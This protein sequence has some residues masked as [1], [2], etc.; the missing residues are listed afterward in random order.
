[1]RNAILSIIGLF[2]LLLSPVGLSAQPYGEVISGNS[3]AAQRVVL[4]ESWIEEWD[5]ATQS[6]V[7]IEEEPA[8]ALSPAHPR[9]E[10]VFAPTFQPQVAPQASDNSAQYGPFKVLDENRVALVGPTDR[11]SPQYF[12]MMLADHPGLEVFEIIEGPGTSDDVGNLAVGRKIREA[13]MVTYVP[14]GGSVRSGAVELFLAGADRQIAEGAEFAVHSWRDTYGREPK[15]YAPDSAE[16]RFYLDYYEEMGMPTDH[17][18]A[19]YDMT[20]SVPHV[21]ALWLNAA[22]MREWTGPMETVV[23]AESAVETDELQID[24]VPVVIPPVTQM[25]LPPIQMTH[26][27]AYEIANTDVSLLDSGLAFP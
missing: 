19:F 9:A 8:Q 7:R 25:E 17:A 23:T 22:D 16:N 20:N 26:T 27:I 18:R 15:D 12:D 21:S 2:T 10:R 13:G 11:Y 6:W 14:R 4:V 5:E 1:M 24:F 3:A